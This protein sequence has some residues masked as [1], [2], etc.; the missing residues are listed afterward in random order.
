M[1]DVTALQALT[2]TWIEDRQ[3][4]L[5]LGELLEKEKQFFLYLEDH[6]LLPWQ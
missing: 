1:G 2:N 3:G 4:C 6:L 5:I